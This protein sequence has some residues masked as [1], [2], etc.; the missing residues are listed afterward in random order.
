M[1]R[2]SLFNL[3]HPA[4][5]FTGFYLVF[6]LLGPVFLI[7]SHQA[8][9]LEIEQRTLGVILLYGV[10]FLFSA[11]SVPVLFG[12]RPVQTAK[13]D[14]SGLHRWGTV[15]L[16]LWLLGALSMVVFYVKA[17]G[18]PALAADV[19]TARITMKQG[20]GR[21]ILIGSGFFTL[22]LVYLHLV[23]IGRR[24]AL[25]T[26]VL[27]WGMTGVAVIM[28][29]GVGFRGPAGFMLITMLLAR[30]IFSSGYQK[31]NR[32]P[33]R[34]VVLGLGLFIVLA[35]LGYYRHTGKFMLD[36]R[37]IIWPTVVHAG[38]LQTIL[39]EFD[40]TGFF[41]GNSFIRDLMAV[42]PG[43]P[44]EF[45]GD[46]LKKLFELEFAGGGITV[47]AP[48]EGYV[49]FGIPGV[50]LH[51]VFM[52]LLGGTAYETLA[53]KNDVQSRILLLLISLNVAR[54]VTSGISPILFFSFLP[55]LIA[56][57]TGKRLLAWL[58]QA[59][60]WKPGFAPRMRAGH[61]LLS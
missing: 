16:L 1:R 5:F 9:P 34:W 45:L 13:V 61:E 6:L 4:S 43:L 3:L 32:L 8:L 2:F 59:D 30:V 35:L 44:G 53:K 42:I 21:Y 31:N 28:L 24:H 36:F 49:N 23:L 39:A 22:G 10:C 47:T 29:M 46:Y 14:L 26:H 37:V 33:L 15:G 48:G 18:I 60:K 58:Y 54:T 19:E 25:L 38:N 7:F 40:N 20:L 57:W 50:V 27:V 52:G 11:L 12:L 56:W 51:A 55:T 17:G 41:L